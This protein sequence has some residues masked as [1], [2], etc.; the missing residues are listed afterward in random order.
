[1]LNK[2]TILEFTNDLSLAKGQEIN[3]HHG[4]GIGLFARWPHMRMARQLKF[5]FANL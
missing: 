2:S 5:R 3:R 1:M 4:Y